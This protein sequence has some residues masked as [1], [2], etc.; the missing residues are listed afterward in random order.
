[1]VSFDNMTKYERARTGYASEAARQYNWDLLSSL[2]VEMIR[3]DVREAEAVMDYSNGCDYIVH[4]AAQ[5]AMTISW[6][7]PVLDFTTNVMGTFNVLEAARCHK[8]PVASCATIHVY[9][10]RINQTLEEEEKRYS[11]SPASIDENHPTMEGDLSPLH[12]SKMAGDMYVRTYANVYGLTAASFRFTGIYGPGQL[13]GEDH[14]WVAN[15]AIRAVLGRP[16]TIFG[17]GKQLRDILYVGDA[18]KAF[19]AFY[20]NPV[21]GVYNIGGGEPA[22]I[23]LLECLDMIKEILGK[24]VRIM[25]EKERYGDLRYFVCDISKAAALL[26]WTPLVRPR[27]GIERLI[28]WIKETRYLFG[29]V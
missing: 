9:G 23:S 16:V 13:G 2:G 7:D 29:T 26:K 10:N 6:E 21:P 3:E 5:P 11:R 1:V 8:I 24:D 14:G 17:T 12:A 28:A 20:K 18:A 4:T 27:E 25:Y 15:F 19:H 22:A